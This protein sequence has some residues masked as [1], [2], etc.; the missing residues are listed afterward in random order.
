MANKILIT[1][2]TGLVGTQLTNL[3]KTNDFQVSC[4]S[5]SVGSEDIG[6]FEWDIPKQTIDARAFDGVKAVIHLAGASVADGRWTAQRRKSIMDSRVNSTRLLYKYLSGL[7]TKPEVF[8]SAAAVGIY[9][10]D[11]GDDLMQEDSPTGNDFLAEVVKAWEYEVDKISELG[12]RVVKLRI[13]IVLA[14]DGGAY[15]KIA[16]PIKFGMGAPLG[17]GNQYMSWIHIDDL[18]KMFLYAINS[19]VRGT[20][21][22]VASNPVT[23][24]E[25]TK[26]VAKNLRRPLILPNVPS[27]M[28]KLALGE[29][30][31]IVLGGNKVSNQKILNSGFSFQFDKLEMAVQEIINH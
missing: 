6:L 10:F 15:P 31:N 14:E 18:C 30:S 23:N 3:L 20:F 22:A 27:F 26:V 16:A 8:V 9:G 21:N 17:S 11:T 19:S 12:I 7:T 1:G 29:M 4:L 2:G 28:L 25:F 5:R 24:S 13:G